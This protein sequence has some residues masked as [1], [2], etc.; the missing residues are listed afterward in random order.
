MDLIDY[1]I[2]I[3]KN[4]PGI[5]E[6]LEDENK[7]KI[8]RY[9][10]QLERAKDSKISAKKNYECIIK[11]ESKVIRDLERLIEECEKEV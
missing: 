8:A 1:N 2:E 10:E 11:K 9:K 3:F 4:R 7:F 5:K 6:A